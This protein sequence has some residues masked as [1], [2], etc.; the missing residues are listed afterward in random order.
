VKKEWTESILE[1]EKRKKCNKWK[2]QKSGTIFIW[3]SGEVGGREGLML[4]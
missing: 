3:K 2:N 4:K 1:R